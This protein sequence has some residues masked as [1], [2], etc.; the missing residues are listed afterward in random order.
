M[1]VCR[2]VDGAVCP[3]RLIDSRDGS[4]HWETPT[5]EREWEDTR[6]VCR[7]NPARPLDHGQYV[8]W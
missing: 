2:A 4:R 1:T 3:V 6:F 5:R 8:T 7:S